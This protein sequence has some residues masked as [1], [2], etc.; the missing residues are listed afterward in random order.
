MES[1]LY[2]SQSDATDNLDGLGEELVVA[3]VVEVVESEIGDENFDD[4][5]CC[6]ARRESGEG[7]LTSANEVTKE[8]G[9]KLLGRLVGGKELLHEAILVVGA[10]WST[11]RR[12]SRE[13]FCCRRGDGCSPIGL[14]G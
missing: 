1:G 11:L 6:G 12:Q 2:R 3:T 4:V 9:E 5:G 7:L 13:V 10:G 8:A 14:W